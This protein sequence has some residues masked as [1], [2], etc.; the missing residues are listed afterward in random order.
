MKIIIHTER[1]IPDEEYLKDWFVE[2]ERQ[3]DIP[4]SVLARLKQSGS[5]TWETKDSPHIVTTT[6]EIR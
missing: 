3:T 6:Y 5:A 1:I 2:M 4:V